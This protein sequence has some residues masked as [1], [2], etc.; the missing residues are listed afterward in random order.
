MYALT[1]SRYFDLT[2]YD[3]IPIKA[4]MFPKFL[5]RLTPRAYPRTRLLTAAIVWSAVGFFLAGKG[6]WLSGDAPWAQIVVAILAGLGLGL[7]KS[8]F[9]F[10]RVAQK[11]IA[12]IGRKPSR[13][14]LGGLFSARNWA[15]IVVMAVFGRTLGALPLD[16]ALKTGIYVM[17]GSGL[18]YSSRLLWGAWKKSP[19]ALL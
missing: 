18:S 2:L 12:H 16:S 11:I 6:V 10:D 4:P 13:A 5:D 19:V 8:R 7:V 17:V 9:I 14:C 1:L 15:L 3:P